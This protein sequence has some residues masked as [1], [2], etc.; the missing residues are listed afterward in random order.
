MTLSQSFSTP[1][2][3]TPVRSNA[4]DPFG[5]LS[6]IV[7]DGPTGKPRFAVIEMAGDTSRLVVP[8]ETIGC[9]QSGALAVSATE[10][11]LKAAPVLDAYGGSRLAQLRSGGA[12]SAIAH[13]AAGALLALVLAFGAGF[14]YLLWHPSAASP[15][16]E[17]HHVAA[18]LRSTTVA[19]RDTSADT[20]TT[21]KVMTALALSK[22]VAE[23][24]VNVETRHAVT[25]LTGTV[26]SVDTREVAG[27]IAAD[28]AGV[29]EV[30][31]FITVDPASP[32]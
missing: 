31:N 30:R 25:T 6:E 3:G 28:T 24:G 23:S 5:S 21:M 29:R 13:G 32:Q 1:T 9:R 16:E 26:P 12:P 4:G 10:A 20:V 19:V 27:Q 18:A 2:I 22:R 14:G 8:W 15:T 17:A 11:E 7:F